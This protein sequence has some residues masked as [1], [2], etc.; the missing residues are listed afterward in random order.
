[1]I[2]LNYNKCIAIT[3]LEISLYACIKKLNR[4]PEL[5][6]TD[7]QVFEEVNKILPKEIALTSFS[8]LM[9]D[10]KG[11]LK[12][13]LEGVNSITKLKDGD[14]VLVSEG[15]THHRQCSDIGT[16][17]IPFWLERFSGAKL[18]IETCSGSD[19]P[20]TLEGVKLVV[21]CG[22]C[23]ISEKEI[24][25]RMEQAALEEVPFTNYGIL[26]AK[27]KG[28]LDRTEHRPIPQ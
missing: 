25:N 18:N 17:K 13:A 23:M 10:Y 15:C 22:G 11:F 12:T 8:I 28:I 3:N 19:F 24:A 26:I 2:L 27:V 21:H 20:E 6:I 5:V 14:R 9:A 16:V 4:K 1:M 7:S